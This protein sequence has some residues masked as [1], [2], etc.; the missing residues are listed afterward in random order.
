M[1]ANPD[2][3]LEAFANSG[4]DML[5]VHGETCPRN[6]KRAKARRIRQKSLFIQPKQFHV[7][8]GML[9]PLQLVADLTGSQL[10]SIADGIHHAGLEALAQG[11]IAPS[12]YE[13]Y[14]AFLE[15][16]IQQERSF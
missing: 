11:E 2:A 16:V 4:A 6:L 9:S 13:N 8:C 7:P 12:R 1:I 10:P 14:L 5:V 15:E 3:Y